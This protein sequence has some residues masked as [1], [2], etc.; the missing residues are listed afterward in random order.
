MRTIAF[1]L[2]L[3]VILTVFPAADT[4]AADDPV[5]FATVLTS[6]QA[7]DWAKTHR[8]VGFDLLSS[9]DYPLN[10]SWSEARQEPNPPASVLALNGQKVS[11]RGY[12]IPL[13]LDNEGMNSF[14]VVPFLEMCHFGALGGPNQWVMVTMKGKTEFRGVFYPVTVFGTLDVGEVMI[15]GYFESFYRMNGTAVYTDMLD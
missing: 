9:F 12:V 2:G 3:V 8:E 7:T 6:R 14:I 1:T 5:D 13:D 10:F 11:I 15:D 4:R